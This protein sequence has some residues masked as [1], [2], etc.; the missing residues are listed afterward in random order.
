[1]WGDGTEI[2]V[3]PYTGSSAGLVR[4]VALAFADFQVRHPESFSI[5][6]DA[7]T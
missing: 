4:I 6:K 2:L 1:L 3:D 5:M 7:L